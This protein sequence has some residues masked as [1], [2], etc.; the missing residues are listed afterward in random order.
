MITNNLDP[1]KAGKRQGLLLC[2]NGYATRENA[3]N[4][5]KGTDEVLPNSDALHMTRT[6]SE[7]VIKFGKTWAAL[8]VGVTD[9]GA[10]E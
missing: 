9:N 5:T 4:N 6:C 10:Y 1:K 3:K 8:G 2:L 7:H